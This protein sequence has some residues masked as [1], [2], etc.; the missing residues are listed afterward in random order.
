MLDVDEGNTEGKKEVPVNMV[1]VGTNEITKDTGIE[2]FANTGTGIVKSLYSFVKKSGTAYLIRNLG[3]VLQKYNPASGN[4]EDFKTGLSDGKRFGYETYDDWLYMGNGYDNYMRYD[5]Q[6]PPTEYVSA[7]KGNILCVFEDRM[8]IAGNP[9]EPLTIYYSDIGNPTNFPVANVIKPPG[10]DKIT[11]LIKYYNVLL[12]L[13]ENSDWRVEYTWDGTNWIPKLQVVSE[14]YGCISP[15][16]YCWVENDVWFFTGKEV[17]RIGWLMG[18][19]EVRGVLGFDPRSLSNQIKETLKL[20]N[21]EKISESA[22]IYHNKRFYLAVPI[23]ENYNDTIFICH[24][25]YQNNWTKLKNRKKAKINC[26]ISHLGKLYFAASDVEGRVY[27]ESSDFND[28]GEAIPAYVTFRQIGDKDFAT[29]QIYRY[30]DTEFKNIIG[31]CQIDLIFDDFDE[32]RKKIKTFFVGT[33]IEGEEN[34]IG[35]INFGCLLFGNGFGEETKEVEYLKRRFSF[36]DKGQT[37][38]IKFSNSNLNENFI[39]S[40]FTLE[41]KGRSR[42]HISPKSM[43][44]IK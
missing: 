2:N 13:K 36:L 10:A 39:L 18:R 26:F 20:A 44:Y 38:R 33:F 15:K 7:P 41:F 11:G 5:G 27:K 9:S 8:H 40:K 19:G 42:R 31:K 37:I 43:I 3:T 28:A 14:N 21:Q 25:L 16:A 32:R 12:V 23:K 1:F 4:F 6:N 22:V 35:E 17:R 34:T 24:L 30:L 29:T